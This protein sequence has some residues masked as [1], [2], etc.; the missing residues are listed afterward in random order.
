[1]N[2]DHHL[3]W[4]WKLFPKTASQGLTYVALRCMTLRCVALPS[5]F[6]SF[7][8]AFQECPQQLLSPKL[9]GNRRKNQKLKHLLIVKCPSFDGLKSAK[10]NIVSLIGNKIQS[11]LLNF[12]QAMTFIC[13]GNCAVLGSFQ[14]LVLQS[15]WL[16][17]DWFEETMPRN[18]GKNGAETKGGPVH[19]PFIQVWNI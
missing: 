15:A 19:V 12:P 14:P 10:K 17:M 11:V 7:K 8:S 3:K 16:Q 9:K 13:R 18:Q 5:H 2:L 6:A 4:G 1:M